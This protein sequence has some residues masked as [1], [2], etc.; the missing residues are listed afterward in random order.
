V[1]EPVLFETLMPEPAET[2]PTPVT[3]PVAPLKERT[4]VFASAFPLKAS[5]APIVGVVRRPPPSSERIDEVGRE[6]KMVDE[7]KVAVELKVAPP[8]KACNAVHETELAA[9]RNPGFVQV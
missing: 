6:A 2:E 1:T 8:R 3:L 9:V 5:P 7:L 4:P